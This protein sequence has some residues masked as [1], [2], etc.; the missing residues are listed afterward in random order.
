[1]VDYTLTVQNDT[2]GTTSPAAGAHV[3]AAGTA[4]TVTAIPAG[5]NYGWDYWTVDGGA[6]TSH[7]K[8]T[9][10]ITMSTNFTLKAWFILRWCSKRRKA[11]KNK[12]VNV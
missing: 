1:M 6:A 3:Y 12:M 8:E 10:T 4:V 5:C 9:Y 2:G 7:G 11:G